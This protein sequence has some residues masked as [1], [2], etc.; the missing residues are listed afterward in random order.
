MV[1]IWENDFSEKPIIDIDLT[2]FVK[3]KNG[4]YKKHV[5]EHQQKCYQIE[6]I[7]ELAEKSGL[8]IKYVGA[9][10]FG[11]QLDL[12]QDERMYFMAIKG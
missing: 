3:Q 10:L 8:F 1:L 6:P 11:R 7:K 5:E 12:S 4:L 9:D 2:F